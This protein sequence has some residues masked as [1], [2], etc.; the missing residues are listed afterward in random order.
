MEQKWTDIWPVAGDGG[1]DEPCLVRGTP[2][3]ARIDYIWKAKTAGVTPQNAEVGY[4]IEGSDHYPVLTEFVLTIA[5]NHAS[6]FY[7][8]CDEGSGT[9]VTDVTG[10]LTGTLGS[11]TPTWNT[12]SPSG[13]VGDSRSFST[14]TN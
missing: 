3:N 5:T 6:G 12:N 8:P 7:F 13:Q 1:L 11:G 2:F 9:Q 4:G 10:G 14:E